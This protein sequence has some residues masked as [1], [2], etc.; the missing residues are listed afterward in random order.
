[1]LL[2]LKETDSAFIA[3]ASLPGFTA[4]E[5]TVEMTGT[6]VS[7]RAAHAAEK[8]QQTGTWHLRERHAGT[9]LRTFTLP[10]PVRPDDARATLQDGVLTVTIPKTIATPSHQVPIQQLSASST[11][12]P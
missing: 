1:M 7:I 12:S 4:E 10:V 6:V 8:E 9:A 5:I 11:G 3:T 2:D